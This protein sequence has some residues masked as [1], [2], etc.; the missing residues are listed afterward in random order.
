MRKPITRNATSRRD[1]KTY[2][3][4]KCATQEALIDWGI[5]ACNP[6]DEVRWLIDAKRRSYDKE[7]ERK[8]TRK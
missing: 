2:I 8:E 3:C 7:G 1:N 6:K 5:L 4:A